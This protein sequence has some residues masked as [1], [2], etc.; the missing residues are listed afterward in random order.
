MTLNI[1]TDKQM[2]LDVALWNSKKTR[3]IGT[4][5]FNSAKELQDFMKELQLVEKEAG[6]TISAVRQ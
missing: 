1:G 2:K 3:V 6:Y 5:Q 4:A